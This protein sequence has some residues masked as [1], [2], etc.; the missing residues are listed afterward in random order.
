MR[1]VWGF[2]IFIGI[3]NANPQYTLDDIVENPTYK[4]VD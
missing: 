1:V 3:L 4:Y 2:F